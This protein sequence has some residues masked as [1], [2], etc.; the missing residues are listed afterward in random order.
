[1]TR[2]LSIA[3]VALAVGWWLDRQFFGGLYAHVFSRMVSEIA[4]YIG[5]R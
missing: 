1:M 2:G 5:L 4:L 3:L